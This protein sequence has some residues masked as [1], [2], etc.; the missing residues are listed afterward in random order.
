M[1]NNHQNKE[2]VITVANGSDSF[3]NTRNDIKARVGFA[4]GVNGINNE[5]IESHLAEMD[6]FVASLK[7][8]TEQYVKRAME[9]A[10]TGPS[11]VEL[12]IGGPIGQVYPLYPWWN[13]LIVGPFQT[14]GGVQLLPRKILRPGTS[15]IWALLWRNPA[16]IDWVAGNPS[17]AEI[18]NGRDFSLWAEMINLTNV[19]DGPDIQIVGSFSVG[20]Y[21]DAYALYFNPPTP[22]QGKPDL[23]EVNV[24]LDI[25]EDSQPMAGFATWV[26]DLDTEPGFL[27]LPTVPAHWHYE[28]P[29]R[30][31][32]YEV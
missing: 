1:Y 23:Y 30:F 26:F 16:P 25:T 20:N 18:M 6:A 28:K 5:L 24:T 11:S 27:G 2:E 7:D 9:K 32:V 3:D 8:R 21:L 14:T 4:R 10:K 31:L 29:M 22:V 15:L 12:E 13:L 19:T 17:A